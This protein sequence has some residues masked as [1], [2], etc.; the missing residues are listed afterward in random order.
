MEA[1]R[2]MNVALKLSIEEMV[3]E[4]QSIE[5]LYNTRYGSADRIELPPLTARRKHIMIASE[6]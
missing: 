5:Q 6:S 2:E 1:V 4:L 3:K